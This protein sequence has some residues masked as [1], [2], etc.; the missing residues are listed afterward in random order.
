MSPERIRPGSA[1]RAEDAG[2]P[3]APAEEAAGLP[4]EEQAPVG[5]AASD[6]FVDDAPELVGEREAL[7]EAD[8]V[9]DAPE[10]GAPEIGASTDQHGDDRSGGR[11]SPDDAAAGDP[12]VAAAP[13][14]DAEDL[15]EAPALA[16]PRLRRAAAVP[17]AAPEESTEERLAALDA[18]P[19]SGERHLSAFRRLYLGRTHFDFVRRRRLWFTISGII[20]L[21]GVISLGVRGLNLSIDFVGGTSWTVPSKTLHVSSTTA[22]ND[23]RNAVT[24]YGLGGA[25]I[26]ELGLGSNAT[27]EVSAKLATSGNAAATNKL[28]DEVAKA[29]GKLTHT[30]PESVSIT[31]IGPSW[32]SE[33]TKK[34]IE[35]LIVFFIL[36]AIYISIFFEWRMALAAI[37]AVAHDVLV[38]IGIY[39]LSGLEVSPDTVVAVLTI[40]GYSLYDTIVVFDRV[41]DNV[42]QLGPSNKLTIS[43]LVNL[44][45]N[46]TLARSIN[47]SLVAIL[48]ILAVLIL[49]AEILGAT[50]LEYFGFA[51]LIGLTSGAYSSI[52]IAAPLVSMMKEREPRWRTV[53]E[54]LAQR[55]GDRLLL[56]PAD[57]AAGILTPEGGIQRPVRDRTARQG[58]SPG[59]L[60]PSGAAARPAPVGD[61]PPAGADNGRQAAAGGRGPAG[62]NGVSRPPSRNR[63]RGGRR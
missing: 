33:I 63:R 19:A 42:R 41:R 26:T 29:L 37:I 2:A 60:R 27:I 52:F 47:T 50:T 24:P 1:R 62:R 15:L 39:S 21:A 12:E 20:L 10:I 31:S 51:L 49:G 6:A 46:Q 61:P 34:A 40:L 25:T 14:G 30:G 4:E 13:V 54:R 43:D 17:P 53:R 58:A 9:L 45:M 28:Q 8:D 38:V 5:R 44:S 32:G 18:T 35:A 16:A 22:V 7:D 23:A 36:V 48:P 11:V 57:I 56:S 55:G 3:Q 59:R